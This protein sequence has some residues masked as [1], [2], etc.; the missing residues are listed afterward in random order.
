[1]RAATVTALAVLGLGL[2]LSTASFSAPSTGDA[3]G[4]YKWQVEGGMT[5]GRSCCFRLEGSA[6]K[7]TICD[8][9]AGHGIVVNDSPCEG[10]AGTTAFYL[11]KQDGVP[12][13]I[14][15]FDSSC[16]VSANEAITN[17]GRLTRD[18]S[19]DML[20]EIVNTRALSMDVRE[21]ALFWLAQSNTDS[22]FAY[23]DKLLSEN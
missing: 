22:A 14:R 8:L 2:L 20:V 9:D 12:T 1:M 4:W 19:V 13:S 11:R 5:M 16:E 3:D 17:M 15:I 18:D 10:S 21:E 7:R 23:F 6:T